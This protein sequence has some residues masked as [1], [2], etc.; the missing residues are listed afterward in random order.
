MLAYE[1]TGRGL[2]VVLLHAFPLSGRMWRFQ[3]EAFAGTVRLIIPDLPSFGNSA[4]QTSPSVPDMAAEVAALLDH[5][6]IHEPVFIGGLSMGGYAAFEFYRQFPARVRG[7]GLFSTRAS[8]DTE[9]A[10]AKRMKTIE[11]IEK[12]GLEPFIQAVTPNLLGR[13]TLEKNPEAAAFVRE[14]ILANRPEGV[15][16]SLR[17]MA[18]RRDSTDLLGTIRVPVL[19]AAGDEDLFIP[20]AEAEK[21]H[22]A[23]P[24]ALFARMSGA[25]HLVNL[26]TPEKFNEV[27]GGFLKRL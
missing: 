13:T 11:L 24:G 7:L 15:T 9:E 25:G 20:L 21:M 26:E 3:E 18:A 2:P 8:A 22:Q 1:E 6:R 16:D 27:L 12:S 5:L 14:M 23:V 19:V 4:R 17:A 10:R